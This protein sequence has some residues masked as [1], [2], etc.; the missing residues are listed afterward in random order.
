MS[1]FD[2]LD[3]TRNQVHPS[4]PHKLSQ[5][6][7]LKL[8][9]QPLC[10]RAPH[11]SLHLVLSFDPPL[12]HR[13][14]CQTLPLPENVLSP[15]RKPLHLHIPPQTSK[16]RI[17]C[18]SLYIL[19]HC[20]RLPPTHRRTTRAVAYRQRETHLGSTILVSSKMEF[21]PRSNASWDRLG[22]PIQVQHP[23]P[24]YFRQETIHPDVVKTG[25]V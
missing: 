8:Y 7:E 2:D 24:P 9:L 5:G 19:P 15:D 16:R 13:H 11:A 10:P 14:S 25:P 3:V 1:S 17:R 21:N 6:A 4:D 23:T 22:T 18:L 20:I 12:G